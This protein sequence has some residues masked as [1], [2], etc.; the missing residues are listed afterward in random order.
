M[1]PNKKNGDKFI[2]IHEGAGLPEIS[3]LMPIY[4]QPNFISSAIISILRQK[5][6]IA[7]IIISD[8]ASNDKTFEIAKKTVLDWI[9][10]NFCPHKIIIRKGLTRLWRDHLPLLVDK[11]SCDIVCQAHGDDLSLSIRAKAILDVFNY[12]PDATLIFSSSTT[13]DA[14]FDNLDALKPTPGKAKISKIPITEVIMC[15]NSNLLGFSQSWRKSSQNIFTRLDRQLSPCAHDRIIP[16]RSALLGNVYYI[17][18]ALVKRRDH[19]HAARFR[20]FFEPETNGKF[21]WSLQRI[22]AKKVMLDDLS[23]FFAKGKIDRSKFK[24]ITELIKNS[25]E[26]D[27]QSLFDAFKLQSLANRHLAWLDHKSTK[28]I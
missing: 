18:S 16:F 24:Y 26:Q 27:L 10:N 7:E 20:M 4:E 5:N 19:K 14:E 11:A 3:I 12:F 15:S 21:G 2:E 8:D 23:L 17:N 13:I 22:A 25:M 9:K 1:R 6:I 28:I